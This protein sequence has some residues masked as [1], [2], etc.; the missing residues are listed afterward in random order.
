MSI[1]KILTSMGY[2][3]AK[4]DGWLKPIGWCC[5]FFKEPTNEIFLYFKDAQ[6]KLSC[7]DSKILD[8]KEDLLHQIKCFEANTR[9]DLC[10]KFDSNFEYLS[11]AED[12]LL[13]GVL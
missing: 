12:L 7:W 1:K 9:T 4:T 3:E 13:N 11:L 10:V 6:G 2:R 5:F 8:K